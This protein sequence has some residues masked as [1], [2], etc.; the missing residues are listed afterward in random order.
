[1]P[2]WDDAKKALDVAGAAI[3]ALRTIGTLA[4]GEF[5]STGTK[6]LNALSVIAQIHDALEGVLAG[7]KSLADFEAEIKYLNDELAAHDAATQ[8]AIDAKFP[9]K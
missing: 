4:K 2:S 1:M 6:A 9:A 7:H 8:A 5:G 3:D